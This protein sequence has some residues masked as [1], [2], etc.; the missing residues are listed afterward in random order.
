MKKYL[1]NMA[2]ASMVCVLGSCNN[3]EKDPV[4]NDASEYITISTNILTRVAVAENGS[5]E[6]ENGDKI[7]VYA[8]TGSK[9]SVPDISQRVVD[10]A[11]NTLAGGTWQA[12]PQMLWKNMSD[13]H[14]FIG[15]Y[16]SNAQSIANLEES[17][18]EVNANLEES[19]LL[20]ATNLNG[21]K[22]QANPVS[23][24]FDHL[25]A[26]IIVNLEFRNQWGAD[27]PEV[28]SVTLDDVATKCKVN[29]LQKTVVAGTERGTFA[30]AEVKAN[31]SYASIVVPQSGIKTI[32]VN[33][34][35][36]DYVYQ[37]DTDID[38]EGRKYTIINLTV[39]RN[40]LSLGSIVI[41]DWLKGDEISGGEALD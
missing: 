8:W 26:K 2:L 27:G 28:A 1:F 11:I 33:I 32:K 39:G 29:Y 19:D 25:L 34:N 30:L 4:T 41:N 15:V 22:A 7:S 14:F 37:H 40:E 24:T 3:G 36:R 35:G 12:V 38:F 21:I 6:F 16:P 23:L 13:E 10:N 5:Q 9:A 18:F 31:Q 20:V 17:D